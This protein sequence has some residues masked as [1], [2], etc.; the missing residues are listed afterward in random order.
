MVVR[1]LGDLVL[2][3]VDIGLL[4]LCLLPEA[5]PTLRVHC[6]VVFVVSLAIGD[7]LADA[8]ET[9]LASVPGIAA[10]SLVL[11]AVRRNGLNE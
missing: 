8:L 3:L 7:A 4:L 1:L 9:E 11:S 10:V 5:L 6:G 2:L